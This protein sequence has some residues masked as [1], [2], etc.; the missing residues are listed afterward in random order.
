MPEG[1]VCMKRQRLEGLRNWRLASPFLIA[2]AM[3]TL[4]LSAAAQDQTN[5]PAP[6]ERLPRQIVPTTGALQAV[7]RGESGLGVSGARVVLRNLSTG[8][9]FDKCIRDGSAPCTTTGDGVFLMPD[10]PP[11]HY[12]LRAELPGFEAFTRPDVEVMA[13]QVSIL[14]LT[15]KTVPLASYP[16]VQTVPRLPELGTLGVAPP[17]EPLSPYHEMRREP[18]PEEVGGELLPNEPVP[19]DERV[20]T[21]VPNRWQAL[22]YPE[23]HRYPEQ[24]RYVDVQNIDGHWYDPF[25][26][27]KLK[28]DYPIIGNQT[29]LELLFAS[30]TFADGRRL[31]TPSGVSATNPRSS[32]FYGKFGQ[33]FMSENLTFSATLSHG[34]TAFKPVDWQIRFTPEINLNYLATKEQGIVNIDVRKGTDRFDT[35]TVGLQEAFAEVKLHDL[36]HEFDFVSVRL[37]IQH[38]NS[39]FRGF[40]FNDEEP[41]VRIFGNFGSNR[42]QYN[43]AAFAMLEKDTN[44]GLNTLNYRH[45]NVFIANV[46]KQDFL[47][48]GYTIQASFDYDMD[49][50]TVQYDTNNFLVRPA[51][52][53]NFV[54]HK[55]RSYYYGLTGDGHIKRINVTHA[56]YQV[57]GTDSFNEVSGQRVG[58][59]AQMAALELSLDKDWVRYRISGFYSSGD[60]DSTKGT[61]HGFDAIFDNPNFAGGIFSFWN[62]EGIR[63]TG[64]GVGLVSGNSLVP[65]LRSSKSQGQASYVNPGL[66]LLNAGTDI[67]VTTKMRAF[68]NFNA[69]RFVHTEPLETIIFQRPIHDGVGAD[70]GIGVKYRPPLSDNI[71]VTAGFNAFFP[72]AGFRDIYTSKTLYSA[73]VNVRFQF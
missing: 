3:I 46:Y 69:V 5:V 56:F 24:G 68:I 65:S 45:Q 11:G 6:V 30:D 12:E 21:A 16:G 14:E 34:D 9:E 37:G 40:I 50:A 4:S 44:S 58:I 35:Y 61:A 15:M 23:Y 13:G 26:R 1:K 7:I 53:G 22:T 60:R 48:P 2:S 54:P 41:G 64:S 20:F 36:S 43:V 28:G 17:E 10:L 18:E 73:F 32:D 29:F 33:F 8:K 47:T 39:D 27:N 31:P 51:P 70:S 66:M 42:W 59:N 71:V 52:F 25:N 62:R 19:E 67:D 38:F 63:L 55:I 49:Q 57:L 72:W